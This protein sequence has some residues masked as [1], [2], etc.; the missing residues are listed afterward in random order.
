MPEAPARVLTAPDQ[1]VILVRDGGYEP[2]RA[3]ILDTEE[4]ARRFLTGDITVMD[5]V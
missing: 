1:S 5:G 2:I 4:G 3:L